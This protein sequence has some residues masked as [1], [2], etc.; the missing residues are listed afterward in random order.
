M[1]PYPGTELREELLKE[2]LVENKGGMNNKYEGWSTYNGEFSQCKTKSGLMPE[3]IE[4][5]VYEEMQA[6]SDMRMVKKFLTGKLNFPKNNLKHF[7]Y[8]VITENIP[9]AIVSIKDIGKSYATKATIER[10]RK[11]AINQFNI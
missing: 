8:W 4:R 10:R 7:L 3:D 1:T 9:W 6:F 2:G 5:F 11:M